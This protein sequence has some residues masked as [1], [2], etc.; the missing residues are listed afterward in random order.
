M[1]TIKWSGLCCGC[2]VDL[3]KEE[4][5]GVSFDGITICEYCISTAKDILDHDPDALVL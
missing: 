3:H 1:I 4:I 5:E 2:G